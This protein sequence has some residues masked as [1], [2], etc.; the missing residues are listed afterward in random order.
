MLTDEQAAIGYASLKKLALS[1]SC[2]VSDL[3]PLDP[4]EKTLNLSREIS[5]RYWS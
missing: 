3:M 1:L 2:M 5:L 4:K